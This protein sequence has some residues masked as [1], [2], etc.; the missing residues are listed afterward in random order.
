MTNVREIKSREF[1][2][3]VVA[4]LPDYELTN[5]ERLSYNAID[6]QH[7][8]SD[9]LI[10]LELD[11]IGYKPRFMTDY[12]RDSTTFNPVRILIRGCA[13]KYQTGV[14]TPI[15][16]PIKVKSGVRTA[17][18]IGKLIK[19]KFLP[20]FDAACISYEKRQE[21]ASKRNLERQD[22]EN[23]LVTNLSKF[24]RSYNRFVLKNE[25]IETEIVV[26]NEPHKNRPGVQIKIDT[27]D[28]ELVLQIA[29]ILE[30]L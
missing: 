2:N 14:T 15:R 10:S 7:K 18:D 30:T 28:P 12:R 23:L 20:Q 4:E 29:K 13:G 21:L 16:Y 27:D 24:G 5:F 22:I 11:F 26:V 17:G 9:K 1:F 3:E 19:E 25:N 6:L 8:I